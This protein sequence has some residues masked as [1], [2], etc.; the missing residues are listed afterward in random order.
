MKIIVRAI[1][2]IFF[3]CLFSCTPVVPSD[4]E[5]PDVPFTALEESSALF[6]ETAEPGEYQFYTNDSSY[7][8]PYGMSFW[9]MKLGNQDPFSQLDVSLYKI[10]GNNLAGYGVIFCHGLRGDPAVETMLVV[11]I[12]LNREY[13]IGEVSGDSFSTLIPWTYCEFLASGYNQ[14]NRILISYD[15]LEEEFDLHINGYFIISFSDN[16]EPIHASGNSGFLTVISPLDLFPEKPVE[17]LF[18]VH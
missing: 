5:N 3:F 10:S 4:S 12:N 9:T 2:G 16:E 14:E 15:S 11:M 1:P 6:P 7:I 18:Q 8:Q 13:I 17:I